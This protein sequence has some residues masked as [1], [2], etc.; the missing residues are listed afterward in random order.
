M[1]DQLAP[2]L[3]WEMGELMGS[4][5]QNALGSSVGH[6]HVVLGDHMKVRLE[7]LSFHLG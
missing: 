1:K 7:A 6:S 3:D 2:A 4:C 5:R